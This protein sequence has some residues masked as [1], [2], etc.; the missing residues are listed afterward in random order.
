MKTTG[1]P[2]K[3][4]ELDGKDVYEYPDGS[5]GIEEDL[6]YLREMSEEEVSRVSINVTEGEIM[7]ESKGEEK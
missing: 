1:D 4:G 2:I 5:L 7:K 3:V 6:M